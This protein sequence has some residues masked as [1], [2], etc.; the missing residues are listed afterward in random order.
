VRSTGEGTEELIFTWVPPHL[1]L[2]P[3]HFPISSKPQCHLILT[4]FRHGCQA[5]ENCDLAQSQPASCL[6]VAQHQRIHSFAP[7]CRRKQKVRFLRYGEGYESRNPHT[8]HPSLQWQSR[9]MAEDSGIRLRIPR[10]KARLSRLESRPALQGSGT[11]ITITRLLSRVKVL[12]SLQ[13][14]ACFELSR[15]RTDAS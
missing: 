12:Q 11:K 14:G 3:Q 7:Y 4:G 13:H 2:C 6:S 9:I 8:A 5:R 10:V 15:G 1:G